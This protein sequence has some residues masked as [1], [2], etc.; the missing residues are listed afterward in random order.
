MVSYAEAYMD[1]FND[2]L[3]GAIEIVEEHNKVDAITELVIALGSD[4]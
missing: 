3:K 4:E 1:G 2:A